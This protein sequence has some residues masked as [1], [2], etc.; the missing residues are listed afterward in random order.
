MIR[1]LGDLQALGF[2]LFL[3]FH[4]VCQC[5]H[6]IFYFAQTDQFIEFFVGIALQRLVD[7][8]AVFLFLLCLR[9]LL[10]GRVVGRRFVINK[11]SDNGQH[12]YKEDGSDGKATASFEDLVSHFFK[13]NTSHICL[14][15][16][17][18]YSSP[19]HEPRI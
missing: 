9:L 8:H 7:D 17:E 12:Y 15:N 18:H 19:F 3:Y 10:F 14:Y 4:E 2:T 16:L 11:R 13:I 1:H 5:A 6:F